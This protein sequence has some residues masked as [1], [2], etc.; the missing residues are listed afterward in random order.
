MP[1]GPYIAIEGV[2]GVGK[3]TLARLLQPEFNAQLLLEVFEENPFLS[4]FY[5][6]RAR[7]AFQTQ[8]FFL[9]SRYRQQHHVLPSLLERGPVVSD[10]TFAKDRLF[11]RQ[12]LA[13]DELA[14][15]ER[16]YS[17]LAE[18]VVVP[19]LIVYLYADPP[20]LMERI[21]VRDRSYERGIGREY[22]EALVDAYE[23]FAREYTEAPILKI[24]TN[25]LDYVRNRD[26]LA[27]VVQR[28]RSALGEGT[29][30]PALPRF[31]AAE[32][33]AAEVQRAALRR[34]LA[35]LQHLRQLTDGAS[36]PTADPYYD[37]MRLQERVGQLAGMMAE[38]L[39]HEAASEGRYGNRLEALQ[40]AVA[41]S[42]RSL[43]EGLVD[44]L[45]AVLSLAN[46][47]GIDLESAYLQRIGDRQGGDGVEE[48]AGSGEP[49]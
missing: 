19:D 29:H 3:T 4:D 14:T 46:R 2:I 35:D 11:A 40:E 34:R 17:A 41:A 6:D 25:A 30:Q 10:Y 44:C 9:L 24:D 28:V 27:T 13:G 47:L 36:G 31:G 26:D 48:P 22:I 8:I 45:T 16:L 43:Q 33:R 20:V 38:V 7:Y 42:R 15:Y 37:L 1:S 18:N 12:N 21:A 5:A 32:R 39:V 23:R 49:Q